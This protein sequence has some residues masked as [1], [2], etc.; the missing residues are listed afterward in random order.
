MRIW[1]TAGQERF[2]GIVESYYRGA[3]G[4]LLVYDQSVPSSFD[5]LPGWLD[6]IE[7]RA[8]PDVPVIVVANKKDL[9]ET[10]PYHQASDWAEQ[11]GL[12]IVATSAKT[13]E[14]IDTAF[15]RLARL[16]IGK[17]GAIPEAEK[18]RAIELN[19]GAAKKKCKC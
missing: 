9:P 14:E 6:S 16:A 7:S 13:G 18:P 11:K 2:R 17:E 1:D 5:A 15:L 10:V 12:E 8:E 4:I 19:S 3:Q